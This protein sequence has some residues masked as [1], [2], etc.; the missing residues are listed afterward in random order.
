MEERRRDDGA[1][2]GQQTQ[3]GTP[4]PGR[5]AETLRA[6][7]R[8]VAGGAVAGAEDVAGT[9][10]HAGERIA[11]L[12]EPV[13]TRVVPLV[14]KVPPLVRRARPVRA[15]RRRWKERRPI[16]HRHLLV[17]PTRP[18]PNLFDLHPEARRAPIR[19]MGLREIAVAEIVGT[20]V[21]GSAQRGSDFLPLPRL[22][23]ANWRGRWQRILAANREMRILPPIDVLHAAGGYWVL[24]GHNRVAAA[25]V[26]GQ[27][28]IDAAVSAVRLPGEDVERPDQEGLAAMLA[29]GGGLRAAGAGRLSPGATLPAGHPGPPR[30]RRADDA[31]ASAP[32]PDATTP[33]AAPDPDPDADGT[34]EPP[35]A[36]G[37]PAAGD[38]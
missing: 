22:R 11:D 25:R 19:E 30:A 35:S 3:G 16:R 5:V 4:V 13:V 8:V 12:G 24:D 31:R 37:E 34:D 28:A 20:A 27:V 32:E 21:E 10:A 29:D 18:L 2:G 9:L 14:G 17:P 1:R 15:A 26:L 33:P 23:T 38:S 36:A 7:G 6:A